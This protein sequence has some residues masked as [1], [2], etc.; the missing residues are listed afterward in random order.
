MPI[1]T[2][3]SSAARTALIY[4]TL[5]ALIIVWS[6][7]WWVYLRNSVR[8]GEE[9]RQ[10]TWYY[11]YG[12]LLT[13]LTLLVIGLALGRIGRAARHAEL[14]PPEVTNVAANATE[15]VAARAP[16]AVPINPAMPAV[17]NPGIQ[18]GQPGIPSAPLR[19]AQVPGVA[20]VPATPAVAGNPQ[21]NTSLP[22]V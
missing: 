17:V 14:P 12:F 5:G 19:A 10:V 22:K 9:V 2:K 18:P 6:C 21:A 1:L 13:G 3:P 15:Q 11:C 4:I 8:N 20:P 7:I 16:V